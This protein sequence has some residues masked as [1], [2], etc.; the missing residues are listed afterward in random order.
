MSKAIPALE[1]LAASGRK[2][3][4]GNSNTIRGTTET[5]RNTKER[6]PN[7]TVRLSSGMRGR[8]Q[9]A[10]ALEGQACA[11]CSEY[12]TPGSER[13]QKQRQEAEESPGRCSVS[14]T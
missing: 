4:R 10:E 6:Y 5:S 12:R 14:S 7:Q 8:P 3:H 2:R 11:E 9:P 1:E 13:S